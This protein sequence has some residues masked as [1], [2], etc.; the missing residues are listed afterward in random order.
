MGIGKYHCGKCYERRSWLYG[1]IWG[2]VFMMAT[3]FSLGADQVIFSDDFG[4]T[5]LLAEKWKL[6]P[7]NRWK[8][9][10]GVLS[11]LGTGGGRGAVARVQHDGPIKVSLQVKSSELVEGKWCG[12]TI[13]GVHFTLTKGR[14]WYVYQVEGAAR[15]SGGAF[16]ADPPKNDVWY[17]FEI[18]QNG[19]QWQWLVDGK[20]LAQFKELGTIIGSEKLLSIDTAGSP[21]DIDN[22]QVIALSDA[23]NS[24]PNLL[25]NAS[26]EQPIEDYVPSGWKPVRINTLVPEVLWRD[27]HI[28][29]TDAYQGNC[30]LHLNGGHARGNGVYSNDIGIVP[31]KPVTFSVY[32]K[33]QLPNT[34]VQLVVWELWGEN[35]TQMV[36]VGTQ[37]VRYS[38]TA[39]PTVKNVVR[40]GVV[41][42]DNRSDNALLVDAAQ[43]ESGT[44]A[45]EWQ[46][47]STTQVQNS[48][49]YADLPIP[50]ARPLV[51]ADTAPLIDGKVDDACWD[52]PASLW[53]LVLPKN[54]IPTVRTD[55]FS[56][57]KDGVLYIAMRNYEPDMSTIKSSEHAHD[58]MAIFR[59]DH[60][61]VFLDTGGDSAGYHQLAVNVDGA[62][63]DAGPGRD[64]SWNGSW[65]AVTYR[66]PDFWSVE[67][68]IPLSSLNITPATG[69]HWKINLG[70]YESRL[71]ETTS[72]AVTTIANFHALDR[73]PVLELADTVNLSR[74]CLIPA[75]L[76]VV[77]SAVSDA[78]NLT[79]VLQN[80][81]GQTLSVALT[82]QLTG[83]IVWSID[84]LDVPAGADVA[85]SAPL[86][87]APEVKG[88]VVHTSANIKTT[89][90]TPQL[91]RSIDQ[92]IPVEPILSCLFER[93]LY[94][95]EPEA[96]IISTIRLPSDQLAGMTLKID[97]IGRTIN[98]LSP[99]LNV[100]VA[101]GDMK[102][103]DT[104]LTVTLLD[105]NQQIQDRQTLVLRKLAPGQPAVAIDRVLR[106][107]VVN[108]QP[109]L[110]IAPL[111]AF[112]D[113]T[114]MADIDT[115]INHAADNGFKT[116]MFVAKIINQAYLDRWARIFELAQQRGMMVVAWPGG[117]NNRPVDEMAK[118]IDQFKTSP[119]LLAWLLVDEPELI[120]AEKQTIST[121]KMAAEK[122]P[123]HPSYMNN[124]VLG[125]PSSFAG[126]PGDILSIDD[127][128]TNRPNR[129]VIEMARAV[130]LVNK[131]AIPL[132]RPTWMFLVG[133]NLQ[134]HARMPSADEQVAQTYATVIEGGTGI[135]YFMGTIY[136][137]K[138]WDAT[139][140]T[141][142]E[143]MTLSSVLL[144]GEK[145]P[146]VT[147]N[148]PSVLVTSR[149]VGD[150]VYLISV[151]T[152]SE[153]I[154]TRLHVDTPHSTSD[155]VTVFEHR[156]VQMDSGSIE[157][158]FAPHQRHVYRFLLPKN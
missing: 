135:F 93:T 108:D 67:I 134:N 18:M 152:A 138:L 56:V 113:S 65:Q 98:E 100:A 149:R 22:V 157:D 24:S 146:A 48:D 126:L 64:I 104:P 51:I 83:D 74:Y 109:Y 27:W 68:A 92:N 101:I 130:Q 11:S 33:A 15:A 2:M 122:D 123:F 39:V 132:H 58:D 158:T 47:S 88:S 57:Y 59:E 81:T 8:L 41:L 89:D 79:G 34:R 128:L 77:K 16:S 55:S 85:F 13:R 50:D 75:D 155:G 17:Q 30:A 54:K 86:E 63:F 121:L 78:V 28:V 38:I 49:A 145:A 36:T 154:K 127:Y 117:Y 25:S 44:Q 61:E 60:I 84:K 82:G 143:L 69:H 119:S 142:Q 35:H 156:L 105:E 71:G 43:L 115:M 29:D 91:I 103:G 118:F 32:L 42:L 95:A 114:P 133:D 116:V 72:A 125:I 112:W 144:S 148:S 70:R 102:I 153:P 19:D 96:R 99:H 111:Y 107:P 4:T 137:P 139:V 46:A 141:N 9:E 52:K 37:W 147:S 40:G 151:N 94:T 45:T 136:P 90:S 97:P 129:K 106:A 12:V 131:A 26:F 7:A 31:G 14:F 1:L 120:N 110:A 87:K 20:Q 53:P 124:S 73:Y 150:M 76:A 3:G 23:Q 10:A 21:I 5:G 66:G 62:R 80:R 6:T 140:Q